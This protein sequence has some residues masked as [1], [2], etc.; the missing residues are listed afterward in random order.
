MYMPPT[1]LTEKEVTIR[2][3]ESLADYRACQ[4]AQRK[5]WGITE[6]GYVIPIATMVG[7]NLHG[8]LVLGAFLADGTAA[9]MS[10][11]FLGRLENRICLYSQLTGVVPGFQSMGLGFA[12]KMV[13]RYHAH[14]EG[15][16][17]IAWAFDPLQAGNAHFN[18]GRLG[19]TSHRYIDNMYG[20]AERRPQRGSA[21]RPPDRR[22]GS[23]E[24]AAAQ[25]SC[26]PRR[27]DGT[28]PPDLDGS[29]SRGTTRTAGSGNEHGRAPR[30]A[31]DSRPDR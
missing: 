11:G 6:E 4:E 13:Q 27:A 14:A 23:R 9:A 22:V 15:I 21:D 29:G 2:R 20:R 19:A 3:A 5:A 17:L 8:G 28:S 30:I 26:R 7:A 10:F 12:M 25:G 31:R 16:S 18:L 24:T 1:A